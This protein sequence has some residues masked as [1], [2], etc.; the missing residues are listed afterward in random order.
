MKFKKVGG[1]ATAALLLSLVPNI[2]TAY[3]APTPQRVISLSPSATEI[4]FGIGAGS[5]VIAV[6]DN[7]DFPLNAPFSKLSSFTPNVEAIAAY[8]PDLVVLQSSATNASTIKNSLEKLKIKVFIENTPANIADAYA[9]YLALGAA[10]GHPSRAKALIATMKSQISEI[11]AKARKRS[12]VAIFHE[13]DNTLYS[14]DSSTFVGQ[15]YADFNFLNIADAANAGG[16]P[17]L[18]AESVIKANPKIV[19]LD[20]ATYGESAATVAARP[21]WSGISAVKSHHVIALPLDIPD[22]WGP[23]IVDFYR[24]IARATAKIN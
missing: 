24:F 6:D 18:S 4:L 12:Q 23:R 8:K 7:S 13:L 17:Q 3:A 15:V 14:A 11:I 20:D 2:S 5:Q 19:F 1:L 22:R 16:Y 21:G 9:E 10:T